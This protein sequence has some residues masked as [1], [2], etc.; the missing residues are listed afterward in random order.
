M[1]WIIIFFN[2]YIHY[3]YIHSS[4]TYAVQCHIISKYNF[5][6]FS[7][8]EHVNYVGTDSKHGSIL[9]SVLLDNPQPISD[10]PA[11][12]PPSSSPSAPTNRP[13]EQFKVILRTKNKTI[14][15]TIPPSHF[16]SDCP[17]PREIM[18]VNDWLFL[19]NVFTYFKTKSRS[20]RYM[21]GF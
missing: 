15:K 2:V 11:P 12:S 21:L 1:I 9:M 3:V 6:L 19:L 8:Q 18:K 7:S 5:I 4:I 13:R 20:L 10:K 17:G 16:S 14:D